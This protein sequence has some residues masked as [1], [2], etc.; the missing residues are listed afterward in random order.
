MT[1]LTLLGT[2]SMTGCLSDG[3]I[4]WSPSE[5]QAA[6]EHGLQVN[7]D[8]EAFTTAAE[9]SDYG[10]PRYRTDVFGKDA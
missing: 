6:A 7:P 9:A 10:L 8:D 1:A 2:L 5:I 3:I 4:G